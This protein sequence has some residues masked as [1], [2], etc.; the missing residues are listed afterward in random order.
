MSHNNHKPNALICMRA[1]TSP[2]G[3]L[4]GGVVWWR[5]A[6]GASCWSVCVDQMSSGLEL[7]MREQ[8]PNK[9]RNMAEQ[10]RPWAGHQT[11][12]TP[13]QQLRRSANIMDDSTVRVA[14]R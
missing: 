10:M 9:H 4:R 5:I 3:G 6:A 8:A 14:L 2:S 13:A 7:N 12:R 11:S 1:M